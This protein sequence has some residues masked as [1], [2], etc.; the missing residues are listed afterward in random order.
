MVGYLPLRGFILG[1][2][3]NS[4]DHEFCVSG[5]DGQL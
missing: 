5:G 4:E 2:G 1:S 3:D